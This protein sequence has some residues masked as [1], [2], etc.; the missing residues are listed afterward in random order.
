[1]FADNTSPFLSHSDIN[2][3]FAKMTKELPSVSNWFNANKLFLN[4]KKYNYSF[5]HKLSTKDD[6][7]V[8]LP[9]LTVNGL[10]AEHESSL[11]FLGVR[12]DENLILKDHIAYH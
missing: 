10:T 5:S 4:V 7:P 6:V 2:V 11:K 12:I 1:M 8:W 9:N 3:L